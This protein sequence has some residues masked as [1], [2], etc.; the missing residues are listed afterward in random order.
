MT[1]PVSS[2]TRLGTGRTSNEETPRRKRILIVEDDASEREGLRVFLERS[3]FR[4][5]TA[6]NGTDAL[7]AVRQESFDLLLVDLGLPGMSGHEFIAQLPKES[8]PRVVITSGNETPE[9]VLCALREKA[10][11]YITKPFEPQR[12]LEVIQRTLELPDSAAQIELLSADP[13]WVELRFP[14]DQRI[15]GCVEDYLRKLEADLPER[16]REPIEMAVHELVRNA[17]EWGGRLDPRAKVQITCLRTDHLLLYRIAD[18]G[19]GFDPARLQ[20]AAIGQT[21]G[22]LCAHTYVREQQGLR[23]GGFGILMARSLVDE[24]MYNEAHNE[25]LVLKYLNKA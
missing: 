8:R 5:G 24:L 22:D 25:V 18:P 9:S 21:S 12:L 6:A 13:H 3:G 10:C 17:I 19:A 14:C 2:D 11:Q 7:K 15:A 4:A 20:H 23:P 16:V 1:P